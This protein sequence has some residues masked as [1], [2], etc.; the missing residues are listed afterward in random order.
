VLPSLSLDPEVL[1]KITGAHHYEERMLCLLLLLRM[2]RTRVVFLSSQPIAESVVDYYLHLLPGIPTRHARERLTLL[3]CYDAGPSPLA[4][5]I[6]ARPRLLERLRAAVGDPADTHMTCFNVSVLERSLAVRLGIPIYGCDPELLPLASKSG[7][8]KLLRAAGVP[9]ADGAEDIGDSRQLAEGLAELKL[10]NPEMR[11]AVV[12]L[13][14]GFSGEGNAT[15]S[16]GDAPLDR[17]LRDWIRHRLPDMTFEAKSMAWENYEAKIAEMG[18]VAEAFIEGAEKRSPSAQYRVD[19]LGVVEAISTHDQVL[20][21]RSGQ[22]FLGCRFPADPAYR[23]DIQMAGLKAA[24]SLRD[25]GVLGRFAVDFVS[26]RVGDRWQHFGIEINLRKGGTTHPFLM[27]QF[28]TDGRYDQDI[29]EF[30]TSSG[31]PC[32]YEASDNLEAARY[33]GLT[34][35]DLIDIAVMNGLHFHGGAQEG[36][37]FHLL[38]ALSQFGKFGLMAVAETPARASA[39]YGEAISALDREVAAGA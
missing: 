29:G 20:G 15:F 39:L 21:G 4:A 24:E 25:H 18:A 16:F 27:L 3:S 12:K 11:R 26:V 14:E 37:V 17:G 9:I 38:G 10:R 23:L 1:S 28:L 34:P 33:C 2:P 8:R 35:D 7:G 32:C 19:P 5:K 31:R 6:L 22:V 30:R 13:N 36:V